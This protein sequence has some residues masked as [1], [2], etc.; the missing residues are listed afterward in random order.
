[1]VQLV[2]EPWKRLRFVST[3][4]LTLASGGDL[5]QMDAQITVDRPSDLF[6]LSYLPEFY[7]Y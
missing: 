6:I 4:S 5:L 1:M 7:T 3:L 2:G